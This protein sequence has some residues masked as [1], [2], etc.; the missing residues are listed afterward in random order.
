MNMKKMMFDKNDKTWDVCKFYT[1]YTEDNI[2]MI[3]IIGMTDRKDN[4]KNYLSWMCTYCEDN[5]A[6][7]LE[8]FLLWDVYYQLDFLMESCNKNIEVDMNPY[9]CYEQVNKWVK[10]DGNGSY[11]KKLLDLTK[12]TPCGYYYGY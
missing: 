9:K 7:P 3:K 12:N 4:G 2:K 5:C 10:G 1:I 8:Q 6:M 11:F